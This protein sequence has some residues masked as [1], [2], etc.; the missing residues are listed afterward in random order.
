MTH[1]LAIREGLADLAERDQ[2]RDAL[3]RRIA[4]SGRTREEFFRRA[5]ARRI[6]ER[7][8]LAYWPA[9]AYG[10]RIDPHA[11]ATAERVLTTP[12]TGTWGIDGG[13]GPWDSWGHYGRP[14]EFVARAWFAAGC[15]DGGKFR[16][17][18]R[19]G[20][21]ARKGDTLPF[22][23]NLARGNRWAQ[24]ANRYLARYMARNT[25][26]ALGRLPWY[27][28][29]AAI[30]DVA[31]P[32]RNGRIRIRDLNWAAVRVAQAGLHAAAP[33]IPEP[34]L[35]R[36]RWVRALP[37]VLAWDTQAVV[38]ATL[39][40]NPAALRLGVLR[41]LLPVGSPT[42]DIL[43]AVNLVRLFGADHAALTRFVGGR[44]V[45][46]AGQFTLPPGDLMPG[47][48]ALVARAPGVL[49]LIEHALDIQAA[50]GR[51][52]ETGAEFRAALSALPTETQVAI[53]QRQTGMA[54]WAARDYMALFAGPGK[55]HVGVP[56]PGG[57]VGVS[58]GGY[59][60]RQLDAADPLQPLAGRLV[61]CC[62]HL[63][64]AAAACARAS[65][66]E[67][68]AAIWAVFTGEIMVGQAFVWR[69]VDGRLVIDSAECKGD[70]QQPIAELMLHAARIVVGRLGVPA[71]LVGKNSYGATGLLRRLAGVKEHTARPACT[72]PLGYTDAE[73][74]IEIA[75]A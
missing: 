36:I 40:A 62:Q 60:L 46:D 67:G 48:G 70:L 5:R 2:L 29:W 47:W 72:F 54:D 49:Y 13:H 26:A 59:T 17:Q 4:A 21:V 64:G 8:G 61:N 28:R 71:V 68:D 14:P 22:V 32:R 55:T 66:T 51:A 63:H 65:W 34:T 58:R 43:P 30:H 7:V 1:N 53:W 74:V 37:G 39:P 27:C 42:E 52:P 19:G 45:H 75:R 18:L 6:A 11:Y 35:R 10:P 20:V 9:I 38:F 24:R 15:R 25:I 16:A 56:A 41:R 23:R 57:A 44:S 12:D 33:Y 73:R 69:A 31:V 3:A 50:L